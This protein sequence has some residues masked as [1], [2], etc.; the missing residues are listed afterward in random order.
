MF[1]A[2]ISGKAVN[3]VAKEFDV[4]TS[5]VYV[6]IDGFDPDGSLRKMHRLRLAL[7]RRFEDFRMRAEGARPCKVCGCW[8]LTG[9]RRVTC[10][11]E[12]SEIWRTSSARY[13]LDP[14]FRDQLREA[15]ARYRLA[16]ESRHRK[17]DLAHA[18][19]VLAGAVRQRHRWH[20]SGS[21]ASRAVAT[22]RPDLLPPAA[23]NGS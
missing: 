11:K 5:R 3:H 18:K 19:N 23:G 8:V 6:I 7:D 9:S 16:D 22:V 20:L 14:D 12:C 10:S 4:S 2:F 15:T 13:I 17:G 21:K 1:N